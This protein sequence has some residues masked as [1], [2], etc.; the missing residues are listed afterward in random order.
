[1][2]SVKSFKYIRIIMMVLAE[3]VFLCLSPCTKSDAADTQENV[4]AKYQEY[5]ARF[6]AIEYRSDISDNGFEI[7]EEQVF[8]MEI[9]GYEEGEISLIP[10]FEQNYN[11]MALFLSDT[12]GNIIY[13]TDQLEVNN[14]VLG[15]MEQP[16]C[17]IA[18]I[19]FRDLDLDG[20][21]DIIL[22]TS[23]NDTE[24]PYTDI[25]NK[26]GDVLFQSRTE[27]NFYRDYRI[28][29][30]I[31]RFGMNKSAEFITAFVRD[32]A[33]TEF[34]YTAETLDELLSHGM[35]IITEQCYYRTFGKLGKLQV[36]PGTYRISNYDVFMIYLVNEQGNIVSSLQPMGY[37]DNL[38]AL[39]GISCRDIDGDG[40][41][42]ITVL[43]RYSYEGDGGEL[44]IESDFSIYYQ[45]TGGFSA[46]TDIKKKY[47]CGDDDTM[48]LLVEKARKYWGWE[49]TN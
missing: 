29:D 31:N 9:P 8:P 38:Y 48:E 19:G 18:A 2:K 12:D 21:M 46:D 3:T 30:K 25:K 41:K 15:Q 28:S 22:I 13:K 17:S 44:I 27:V 11:R 20:R 5:K 33:S 1:M 24:A 7:V 6:N 4:L 16:E 14:R 10:A 49:A 40:L 26:V 32:N 34:L 47:R 39:K 37:Y 36:V 23:S 35:E 42:D 43:A 45:R